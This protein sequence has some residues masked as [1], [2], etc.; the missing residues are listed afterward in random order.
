MRGALPDR[1]LEER[2]SNTV[3]R[4]DNGLPIDLTFLGGSERRMTRLN[5]R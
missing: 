1:E 2:A 4:G 5:R 3:C